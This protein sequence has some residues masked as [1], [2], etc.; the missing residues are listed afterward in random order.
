MIIASERTVAVTELSS[1]AA[2]LVL[3]E[4]LGEEAE[5]LRQASTE[6]AAEELDDLLE[7]VRALAREY[8]VAWDQVVAAADFKAK[9]RG[10]FRR[11][12]C[13]HTSEP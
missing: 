5:E 3:I 4:K 1:A 6:D 11:R 8:A 10:G 9:E 12:L 7:V 2:R 13:P